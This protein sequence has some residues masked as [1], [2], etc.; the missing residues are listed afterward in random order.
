MD[1]PSFHVTCLSELFL[2]AKSIHT[3]G[4]R[5]RDHWTKFS[6]MC[7][8]LILPGQYAK[9]KQTLGNSKTCKNSQS[10]RAAVCCTPVPF[11]HCFIAEQSQ[12]RE[13]GMLNLVLNSNWCWNQKLLES[14]KKKLWDQV[15]SWTFCLPGKHQKECSG[16]TNKKYITNKK[17][18][19]FCWLNDR[20]PTDFKESQMRYIS[21]EI[22]GRKGPVLVLGSHPRDTRNVW[23]FDS[24]QELEFINVVS[25]QDDV[26]CS[27]VNTNKAWVLGSQSV[28]SY[29]FLRLHLGEKA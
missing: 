5:K 23:C 7:K 3:P 15:P 4:N 17:L 21:C 28:P 19:A 12:N 2:A 9:P 1:N 29:E 27:T 22:S 14:A 8:Q 25:R 24:P 10:W 6:E 26:A 13:A 11:L 20:T 16:W 18:W